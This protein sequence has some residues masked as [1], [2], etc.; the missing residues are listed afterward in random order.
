MIVLR[1]YIILFVLLTLSQLIANA[2][3]D[4]IVG[5]TIRQSK[6]EKWYNDIWEFRRLASDSVAVDSFKTKYG[7]NF[8]KLAALS[9]KLDLK[10]KSVKYPGFIKFAV[11]VYNWGDK[12]FNSYDTAYVVGTGKRWK[13]Q[14]KN[15]NWLNTYD[16]KIP[17]SIHIGMASNIAPNIG[18]YISYMALSLGYSMNIDNLLA[19]EPVK[20][21]RFEANF[22][23]ALVAFDLFYSKNTGNTMIT[24]LG[25]N[26]KNFNLFKADYEFSGLLLESYGLDMYYFFNNRKYSQGAAYSYSKYQKKSAGSFISGLTLSKQNIKID[27]NTL[28]SEIINNLPLEHRNYHIYYND[29]C[30]MLGYGYNWAFKKNWLYNI[31][32]IPCVGFNHSLDDTQISEKDLFSFNIKAKMALV[33]N[34]NNFFYSITGKYDG[35]FYRNSKYLF[36]N[37][38]VNLAFVAGFRF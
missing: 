8:W 35:H 14:L 21:K 23:C 26:Y 28:P 27:F 15:G 3:N 6:I 2:S 32:F 17:H 38:Y 34:H 22:S 12:T 16:L 9:G 11:D 29:Y 24:K 19:G 18:A 4:D 31:T 36:V 25:D 13:L 20:H 7:H 10:D 30:V 5:D 1:K 33:Y 37:S